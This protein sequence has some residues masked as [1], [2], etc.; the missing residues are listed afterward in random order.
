MPLESE[1]G[2]TTYVLLCYDTSTCSASDLINKRSELAYKRMYSPSYHYFIRKLLRY[3]RAL[4]LRTCTYNI[5]RCR[6]SQDNHWRE[7][8]GRLWQT[9]F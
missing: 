3:M 6:V 2:V 4:V 8:A 1:V 9:D 5:T 7:G